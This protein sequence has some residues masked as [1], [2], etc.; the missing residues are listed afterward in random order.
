MTLP[1]AQYGQGDATYQAAGKFEGILKLVVAF[2]GYMDTLPEA[3]H[4]RAMHPKDLELSID[5]LACFLSGWM[6]GPRLYREKYGVIAIPSAHSHL[7]I[8]SA[9]RDAWLMCMEKALADQDY[10]TDLQGYLLKQL[11][12]PAE[13]CRNLD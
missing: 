13:R 3:Q 2:Y 12:V 5:K 9:E 11:A 4:I 10:S 8:G 6:G 1:K 7:N